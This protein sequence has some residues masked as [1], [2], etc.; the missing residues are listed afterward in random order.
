M[1]SYKLTYRDEFS[2]VIKAENAEQALRKFQQDKQT[3]INI[4]GC[5]YQNFFQIENE[6]SGIILKKT[7]W[8]LTKEVLNEKR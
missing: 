4:V 7:G 3:K 8:R 6:D 5:L 2:A 1:P